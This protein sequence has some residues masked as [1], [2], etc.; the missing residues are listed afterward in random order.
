MS[1]FKTMAAHTEGD[2]MRRTRLMR[3]AAPVAAVLTA[4]LMTSACGDVKVTTDSKKSDSDKG[5]T[6]PPEPSAVDTSVANG[7]WLLGMQSAGGVDAETATTVYVTYNP[8]TGQATARK[9]P[10]VRAGSASPDQA[11]LLVSTDRKWAIPDTE[12]KGGNTSSGK[13][14][15]YS[16]T[17]GGS[18][19]IDIRER[20]GNSGVKPIGWAFDPERADTLR[21]VDTASRVWAVNVAGG[22]ATQ[23]KPLAK[24][25][26]VFINGFNRNTGEPYSESID[27]DAT[28]PAG[29]G[30]ADTSPVTRDDGTVLANGS[31]ALTKLPP[32][33]CRLSAGFVDADGVTWVFCA[34]QPTISTYYLPK[35]GKEWTVFGKP[36]PAVAPEA[37]SFDLVL[38]P[39]T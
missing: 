12:I 14:T 31:P 29:N 7:N 2:H 1:P 20:S 32:S 38:P 9:L 6:A 15:V 5:R 39:A 18:K 19:V 28:N 11:A 25:P 4:V 3:S 30:T 21:V 35:D 10:G 24:G 27:S 37:A 22:R 36:S 13:L 17:S 34:D 26:W 23:E 16:L 33:P 8:T